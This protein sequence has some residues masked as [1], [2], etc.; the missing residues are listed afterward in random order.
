MGKHPRSIWSVTAKLASK[1]MEHRRE[2]ENR[3]RITWRPMVSAGLITSISKVSRKRAVTSSVRTKVL[4]IKRVR[5]TTMYNQ[6]WGEPCTCL[7]EKYSSFF[8]CSSYLFR[9]LFRKTNSL[10]HEWEGLCT[11]SESLVILWWLVT[12]ELRKKDHSSWSL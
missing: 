11:Y 3:H 6:C 4:L 7:I 9:T 8:S 5:L 1:L 10:S 12:E 2:A